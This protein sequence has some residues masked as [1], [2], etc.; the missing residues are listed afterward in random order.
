MENLV[1]RTTCTSQNLPG[2]GALSREAIDPSELDP[3]G[4]IAEL[5]AS[6]HNEI[7][8]ELNVPREALEPPLLMGIGRNWHTG[9]GRVALEFFTRF[10]VS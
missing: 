10:R 8:D 2:V 9:A 6:V 3:L 1:S 5:F 7:V 4:V